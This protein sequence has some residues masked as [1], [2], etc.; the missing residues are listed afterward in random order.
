MKQ[1]FLL[2]LTIF[3]LFIF[4][5]NSNP[6]TLS[7]D[8]QTIKSNINSVKSNQNKAN[9]T[10][11]IIVD[12]PTPNGTIKS[13]EVEET[14]NFDVALSKKYPE[15]Q[16]FTGTC[17]KDKTLSVRFDLSPLGFSGAF[18]RQGDFDIIEPQDLTKNLYQI[19]PFD[20]TQKGWE[21]GIDT[22][23]KREIRSQPISG[24]A[25]IS[26]GS[27]LRTFRLAVATTGEFTVANG[28]Q[29]QAL[30]RINSFLTIINAM[31]I[32]ELS[33]KFALVNN[34]NIIFTDPTTD[35]YSPTGSANTNQSSTAFRGFDTNNTLKFIDYDIGCTLHVNGTSGGLSSSGVATLDIVCYDLFK[36]SMWT[37]YSGSNTK[38][39]AG[40]AA[41]AR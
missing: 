34:T 12:L 23:V 26:S 15:I 16:T 24:K 36:A 6:K 37:Q 27:E 4:A 31:Y 19:T 25:D 20:E 41:T 40:P 13:F 30:S 33:I 22:L 21:C 2:L 11:K 32:K 10:A 3:P 5:Q 17:I 18:V 28:G 38:A 7:F 9:L 14:S 29:T 39:P 1:L 35:P 8:Y